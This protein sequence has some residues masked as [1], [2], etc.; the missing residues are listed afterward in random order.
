M[1]GRG[2]G[3]LN[4]ITSLPSPCGSGDLGPGAY[5]FADFLA[6][7]KQRYWQILPIT[8]VGS[9]QGYSPYS[10][11]SA[12]AG[13]DLLISPES[14][15][16]AG[17]IPAG[18]AD[19]LAVRKQD[20]ADFAAA[21][22][23][24]E[25]LFPA[26]YEKFVRDGN[27]C[28][29]EAFCARHAGWL[30]DFALFTVL[31]RHGGGKEWHRWPEEIR[32][33]QPRAL[34]KVRAACR[35][36][37][38]EV[39]FRQFLFYGQWEALK[40]HCRRDNIYFIGDLP[41]YV[42]HD[43]ADVWANPEIFQLDAQKKPAFVSGVAPEMFN[44]SGQKW[45]HPLF[46]WDVL[47]RRRYDW[48]LARLRH[49]LQL[50]DF[51][52]LDHFQGFFS[53]WE[54]PARAKTARPGRDVEGPGMDLFTTLG[55]SL[56]L[57]PIIAED[58]GNITAATREAIGHFNLPGMK[59]LIF[60][61][62]E[63][64]PVNPYAPHNIEKNSIV[65]TGTHDCNTLRGWFEEEASP[66]D[67]RRLERY[68]G[69]RVRA[70]TVAGAMTRLALSTVADTAIIALQDLLGLGA[71]SRMN[72]PGTTRGNWRWRFGQESLTPEL[73][74]RLAEETAFFGRA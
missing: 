39:K 49:N 27:P 50:Y 19:R 18:I 15:A 26:A 66:A 12:Y 61:F 72:R 37:L 20:R 47:K 55:R 25:R 16:A 58:L 5:R 32:D 73:T 60:A 23:A 69:K 4:H 51:V 2:S 44:P 74:R 62:D 43:S 10:G 53:Y 30:D 70:A 1:I 65:Y 17:W 57:G 56:P 28:R 8:A 31:K 59:P 22:S 63:A 35:A 33:R 46:R 34:Q 48:W 7:A 41:F 21:R 29:Y 3:V 42:S 11:P 64:L 67:R 36:E 6:A 38:E 24:R 45:G 71:D 9:A 54:I 13:N 52:R 68:L 40:E 14:L